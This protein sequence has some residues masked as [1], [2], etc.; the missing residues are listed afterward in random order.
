[1]LIF[2]SHSQASSHFNLSVR[3]VKELFNIDYIINKS[4][5][6]NPN[7]KFTVCKCCNNN[8]TSSK[9]RNGKCPSC[10]KKIKSK[11]KR[12]CKF[13]LCNSTK[14]NKI[15]GYN[16]CKNCTS[17]NLGRKSQAEKISLLFKGENNPN[18]VN[19]ES[20]SKIW[21]TS[22]WRKLRKIFKNKKCLKCGAEKNIHLHHIIPQCFLEYEEKFNIYNII[23]LCSNHHKELHHL[24][25]DIVL[26]P[27]LYQ[28]YKK[29]VQE[30]QQYFCSLP[31]FQSM[32]LIPD[33]NY[34]KLSLVK[35]VPRNYHKKVQN[36]HPEFFE[37][38]FSQL[39]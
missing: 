30:L 3:K 11:T 9:G 4:S 32:N 17:K 31:E 16:I 1:M 26:L 18:Y 37:Q 36:L 33:K 10:K 25:L 28:Q 35:L 24:Q 21:Q 27:I 12:I 38:E 5:E 22:K 19:G 39:V 20:N 13:C 14:F 2:Y 6:Y 8:Y 23:P 15:N 29:D 34:N 7:T